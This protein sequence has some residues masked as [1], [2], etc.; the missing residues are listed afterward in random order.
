M[1]FFDLS[2]RIDPSLNTVLLVRSRYFHVTFFR[3]LARIIQLYFILDLYIYLG[4]ANI[5]LI[6]GNRVPGKRV[7]F[8]QCGIVD[9]L[10]RCLQSCHLSAS[11][12]W[13]VVWLILTISCS[14]GWK[15]L[16]QRYVIICGLTKRKRFGCSPYQ[17]SLASD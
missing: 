8:L 3:I 17:K 2:G 4:C 9:N 1:R 13:N 6:E 7:G 11:N 14:G 5:T 12:C 15:Q 10:P 16:F